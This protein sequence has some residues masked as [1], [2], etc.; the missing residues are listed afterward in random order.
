MKSDVLAGNCHPETPPDFRR[1]WL[2]FPAEAEA[3]L[4]DESAIAVAFTLAS[5][6]Y[7]TVVLR[8]I[9]GSLKDSGSL[10]ESSVAASLN[11]DGDDA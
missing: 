4:T 9:V 10:A 6:T 7:A 3:A 8:E 1:G 5:G 2:E 11:S